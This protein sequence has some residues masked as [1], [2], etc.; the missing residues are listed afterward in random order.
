MELKKICIQKFFTKFR[1]KFFVKIITSGRHFE[2]KQKE[3]HS[4]N[5]QS[6]QEL[7]IKISYIL[8]PNCQEK[9]K[10]RKV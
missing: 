8:R 1:L 6:K 10:S 7:P 3:E 9:K 5:I 2:D 4:S